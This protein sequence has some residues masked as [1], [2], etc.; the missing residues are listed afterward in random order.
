MLKFKGQV[1][2]VEDRIQDV[3]DK[4]KDGNKLGTTHKA[5][6]TNIVLLVKDGSRS[7]P[8]V[9]KGFGLGD[10]FKI[11]KEGSDWETPEIQNYQAKFKAV[12]E[13]NIN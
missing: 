6:M 13:C 4:D 11:P 1:L 9:C 7:V 10:D 3:P 12:P 8:L 2:S 5:R